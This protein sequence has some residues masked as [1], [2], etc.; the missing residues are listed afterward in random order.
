[1]LA[2]WPALSVLN[3]YAIR[4]FDT[5]PGP[6][7]HSSPNLWA[8]RTIAVIDRLQPAVPQTD[9]LAFFGRLHHVRFGA[10]RPYAIAPPLWNL[11]LWGHRCDPRLKKEYNRDGSGFQRTRSSWTRALHPA[12]RFCH[13]FQ[14]SPLRPQADLSRF[15]YVL[16]FWTIC[17]FVTV[18][19][20][21][22]RDAAEGIIQEV[23]E[24]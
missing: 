15:A 11:A 12:V 24:L 20:P 4:I 6:G 10:C 13:L 1:M 3:H 16:D 22:M 2:S 21:T 5:A 9:T 17:A 7:Q 18:R 8:G 19:A 14:V 23:A